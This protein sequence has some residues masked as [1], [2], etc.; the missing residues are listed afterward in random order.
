LRMGPA[1]IVA[2]LEGEV[3]VG[4]H[5]VGGSDGQIWP[6]VMVSAG[7]TSPR[8]VT[9]AKGSSCEQID[10][11]MYCSA[12]RS[13]PRFCASRT[14][15]LG[16]G[17]PRAQARSRGVRG[18][19]VSEGSGTAA[20]KHPVRVD[21]GGLCPLTADRFASTANNTTAG[22]CQ[23]SVCRRPRSLEMTFDLV[24]WEREDLSMAI[25]TAVA[26]WASIAEARIGSS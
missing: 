22:R 3:V 13:A 2:E 16:W 18:P 20:C 14:R 23:V 15:W 12:A 5:G 4:S 26:T 11:P 25:E 7:P 9:G 8:S 17:T 1:A 19:S 24:S 21:Y 6:R 10:A